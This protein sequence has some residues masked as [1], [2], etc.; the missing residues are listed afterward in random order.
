MKTVRKDCLDFTVPV[1]YYGS[2]EEGDKDA[3]IV[4]AMLNEANSQLYLRGG[5][6]Q[7]CRELVASFVEEK[8]G[9]VKKTKPVMVDEKGADGKPTGRKV[10]K[11]DANGGV[12]MASAE[13]EEDYVT[14]ALAEKNLTQAGLQA[15]LDKWIEALGDDPIAVSIKPS[16][17]KTAGPKKLAEE[18]LTN[19]KLA[20]ADTT[21]KK[22][23][24]F[25][26]LFK[27]SLGRDLNP[28]ASKDPVALGWEIKAYFD[29]ERKKKSAM[30]A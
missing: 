8:T 12:Q 9:I 15:E 30:F 14:R 25:A 24:G 2:V 20:L 5:T 10:E 19:A 18:Y 4:G 11:K 13:T 6:A 27:T 7:E 3:G 1:L 17:R 23:A 16:L 28:E 26:K 22:L 21:G 29:E